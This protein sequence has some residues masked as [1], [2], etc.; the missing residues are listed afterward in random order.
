VIYE[1]I[2][3]YTSGVGGDKL[4]LVGTA[5]AAPNAVAIDVATESGNAGQAITAAITN[6]VLSVSGA[7]ASLIDTLTEWLAIARA[8]TTVDTR[9]VAF[10]F[11]GDTYVFQKNT[12][13]DL[14]IQLDNV[15]GITAV[16]IAAAT[17]T[18]WI[19]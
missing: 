17:N 13:G 12:G 18:V 8:M 3:D 10:E 4:D 9:A 6:G 2:T 7:N 14:L 19:G 5:T 11:S 15:T 16:G 1:V